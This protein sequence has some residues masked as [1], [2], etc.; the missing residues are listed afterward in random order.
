MA[1]EI[2]MDDEFEKPVGEPE[3]GGVE[4]FEEEE[5]VVQAEGVEQAPEA[6]ADAGFPL[7]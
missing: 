4:P 6:R 5:E 7:F 3:T 2:K 1:E